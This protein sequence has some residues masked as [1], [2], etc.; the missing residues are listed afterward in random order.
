[1]TKIGLFGG[2]FNPPHIGHLIVAEEVFYAL[3]LAKV[4]FIPTNIPPHKRCEIPPELRYEMTC[5]AISGNPRFDIT[6]IELKRGGTSYTVDT[7]R[8]LH[9]QFRE[10]DF[11]LLVGADEFAQI[12][13]WKE[14]ETVLSLAHLVV[15]L[16]PGHDLTEVSHQFRD[17]CTTIEVPLIEISST[18]VREL[19]KQGRNMEYV[20]PP[21]VARFIETKNLYR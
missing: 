17:R 18:Y 13:T 16:R 10:T 1:V 12:E 14:P 9:G 4:L 8:D 11:Y 20:V 7:L 3:R 21:G 2:S 6:D 5:I 19:V 15:M